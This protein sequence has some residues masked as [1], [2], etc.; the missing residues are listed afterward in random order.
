MKKQ[1]AAAPV[2]DSSGKAAGKI[3]QKPKKFNFGRFQVNK[4]I[5]YLAALILCVVL[6]LLFVRY[7]RH[8]DDRP[9]NPMGKTASDLA[10]REG[11]EGKPTVTLGTGKYV[12]GKDIQT[13]RYM[14]TAERGYGSFVTYEV[15]TRFPEISEMLGF[16]AD[17][18]YVPRIAVTL[19]EN[20]EIEIKGGK[21]GEV[22]FTP[23][24]TALLT[25]LNTGIWVVGL[26]IKPGTYTISS[27]DGRSGS[28]ALMEGDL[29]VAKVLLGEGGGNF[30]KYETLM[31]AEGQVMRISNIPVVL[32]ENQ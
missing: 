19:T 17:P 22:T 7:T 20:Q 16:F 10:L 28:V 4:R 13:G 8:L 26:D 32:F 5:V 24:A 30:K 6:V 25:E 9:I 3:S 23:L 12:A 21:L 1:K 15:D 18:A 11:I 27:K 2:S 14:V 31:L 29:P